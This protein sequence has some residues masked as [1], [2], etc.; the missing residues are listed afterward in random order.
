MLFRSVVSEYMHNIP[1]DAVLIDKKETKTQL[2]RKSG[3]QE[4]V[5]VLF[6]FLNKNDIPHGDG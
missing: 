3:K 6:T 5:E 1:Y 4:V 2:R